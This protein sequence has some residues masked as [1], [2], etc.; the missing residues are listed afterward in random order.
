MPLLSSWV[1]QNMLRTVKGRPLNTGMLTGAPAE[2]SGIACHGTPTAGR[3]S[4]YDA[5]S[6]LALC[7]HNTLMLWRGTRP[8][9]GNEVPSALKCCARLPHGLTAGILH[10]ELVAARLLEE[11]LASH[12]V[13]SSCRQG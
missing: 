12:A 5:T 11:C 7:C 9:T 1:E 10:T 4:Q 13:P 2:V 8:S 3:E 6:R